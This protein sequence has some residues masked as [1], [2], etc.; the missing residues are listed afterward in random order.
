[1]RVKVDR[2]EIEGPDA[3]TAEQFGALI[4]IIALKFPALVNAAQA[5]IPV[6]AATAATAATVTAPSEVIPVT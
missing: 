1:M 5:L 6:T 2:I 4:D 3:M